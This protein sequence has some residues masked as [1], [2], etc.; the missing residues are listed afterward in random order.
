MKAQTVGDTSTLEFMK[1]RR[2]FE[3]N[4]EH[5]IIRELNAAFRSNPDDEDALR[6]IDLLYDAA[7]VSSGYTPNNPAQLSGKIYEMMGM[8]ISGKWSASQ[9]PQAETLE[10]EV[11]EPVQAGGQQ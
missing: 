5:P 1:G 2:V 8:A 4:P 6:A 7:L 11:V 3:I 10:A 9:T